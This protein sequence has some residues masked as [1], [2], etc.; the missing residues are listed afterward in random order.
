M[1]LPWLISRSWRESLNT[2]LQ[3]VKRNQVLWAGTSQ[4]QQTTTHAHHLVHIQKCFSRDVSQNEAA[5]GILKFTT[6]CQIALLV[7]F[8][9][10]TPSSSTGEYSCLQIFTNT[11]YVQT[12]IF[13]NMMNEKWYNQWGWTASYVFIDDL[14][15]LFH[16]LPIHI[17]SPFL[18]FSQWL[19]GVLPTS[20]SHPL[21]GYVNGKYF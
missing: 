1:L 6:H 20:Y 21:S 8:L 18:S 9:I 19:I 16:K 11:Q 5:V 7:V 13:A 14:D 15:F 12:C 17:L 2:E 3:G 4:L 10:Y